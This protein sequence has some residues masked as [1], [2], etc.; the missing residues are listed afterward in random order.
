MVAETATDTFGHGR[1]LQE[2]KIRPTR[3]DNHWFDCMVGCAAAA[4]YQ[5]V[6][7]PGQKFAVKAPRIVRRSIG[8]MMA[9]SNQSQ[10]PKDANRPAPG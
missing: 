4:S 5:N 8:E 10:E 7:T 6:A 3:P 1:A 2:W 9:R